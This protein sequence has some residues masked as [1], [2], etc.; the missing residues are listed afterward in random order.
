MNELLTSMYLHANAVVYTITAICLAI[1]VISGVIVVRYLR[2]HARALASHAQR[3]ADEKEMEKSKSISRLS[4]AVA[5]VF[6]LI[7]MADLARLPMVPNFSS[8]SISD[9]TAAPSYVPSYAVRGALT[10]SQLDTCNDMWDA[11]VQEQE[12]AETYPP[13]VLRADGSVVTL[14][15]WVEG[16]PS[17]FENQFRA[18]QKSNAVL[19]PKLSGLFPSCE[20]VFTDR[21][22]N[23]DL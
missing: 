13:R 12:I 2:R 18:I 1:V 8:A 22:E 20:Q 15:N 11:A 17:P 7:V 5:A 14:D 6:A 3:F 19:L 16:D 9:A 21:A 23:I 4:Y 10:I